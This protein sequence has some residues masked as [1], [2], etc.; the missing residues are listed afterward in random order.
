MEKKHWIAILTGVV[1]LVAVI[2]SVVVI[3]GKQESHKEA[4]GAGKGMEQMSRDD[5][6]DSSDAEDVQPDLEN[7]GETKDVEGATEILPENGTGNQ[8]IPKAADPKPSQEPG[9][10]NPTE[11]EP[12]T[13]GDSEPIELPFLPWKG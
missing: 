12:Q 9:K 6:K 3:T 10:N 4:G 2:I 11:E 13:P 1:V 7:N 8:E 5:R